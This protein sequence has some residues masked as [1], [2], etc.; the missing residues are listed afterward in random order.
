MYVIALVVPL[1]WQSANAAGAKT[2]PVRSFDGVDAVL[3]FVVAGISLNTPM[4]DVVGALEANGFTLAEDNS[5]ALTFTKGVLADGYKSIPGQL[6][7]V[8]YVADTD[9]SRS[10]HLHRP[11]VRLTAQQANESASNPEPVPDSM[12]AKLGSDLHALICDNLTDAKEQRRLCQQNT[13]MQVG[14]GPTIQLL[15]HKNPK[16]LVWIYVKGNAGGLRLTAFK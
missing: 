2:M 8:L 12:D 7:Y 13:D 6:G 15:L 3:A 10:I 14:F 9:L 4:A 11:P 16:L 5:G 1:F